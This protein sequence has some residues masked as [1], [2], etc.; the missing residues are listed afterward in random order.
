MTLRMMQDPQQHRSWVCGLLAV[1]NVRN[2]FPASSDEALHDRTKTTFDSKHRES[3]IISLWLE[4]IQRE[5]GCS[6]GVRFPSV[7]GRTFAMVER[8]SSGFNLPNSHWSEG[9]VIPAAECVSR[10]ISTTNPSSAGPGSIKEKQARNLSLLLQVQRIHQ[11]LEKKCKLKTYREK[12]GFFVLYRLT[13]AMEKWLK[14]VTKQA[15]SCE[16]SLK[17][18]FLPSLSTSAYP[19]DGAM[20]EA[21]L[22]RKICQYDRRWEK[23]FNNGEN[24]G[25]IPAPRIPREDLVSIIRQCPVLQMR[26]AGCFDGEWLLRNLGR[27]FVWV[28]R[29]QNIR[30]GYKSGQ[31][32]TQQD[33]LCAD[34]VW[35]RFCP[36]E[37]RSD[38]PEPTYFSP[39]PDLMW[40]RRALNRSSPIVTSTDARIEATSRRDDV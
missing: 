29:R 14:T 1:D 17:G 19:F 35:K 5:L 2:L 21:I 11:T 32:I 31:G 28:D 24:P 4:A 9:G 8:D 26:H 38:F 12:D 10:P 16:E 18:T 15:E 27:R 20:V 37:R 25:L 30:L 39:V 33:L 7:P 23:A 34:H 40:A 6:Y 3:N 36:T 13:T 22:A